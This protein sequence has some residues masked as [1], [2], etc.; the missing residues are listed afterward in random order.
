MRSE[1]SKGITKP[2]IRFARRMRRADGHRGIGRSATIESTI[3]L[4]IDI[5]SAIQMNPSVWPIQ[6]VSGLSDPAAIRNP[7]SRV[8]N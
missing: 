1:E 5:N 7:P 4:N 6:T 8:V 2:A 3:A